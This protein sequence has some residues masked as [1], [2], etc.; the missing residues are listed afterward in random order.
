MKVTTYEFHVPELARDYT[1]LMLSDLHGRRYRSLLR[2]VK[3]LKPD[4]ILLCG[5][6]VDRHYKLYKRTLPFFTKIANVAPTYFA[7][8]NHEVKFPVLSKEAMERT[9]VTVLDNRFV[10][11]TDF[12]FGGLTPLIGEAEEDLHKAFSCDCC[13][14]PTP[15]VEENIRWLKDFE[16]VPKFKILLNHRPEE[17]FLYLDRYHIDLTLSGHAHG[18]QWV[19]FGRPILA[20]GQGLF[21]NYAHGQFG[22][23]IV[24][25][26]CSNTC[27][28]FIPRIHNP[29]ELVLLRFHQN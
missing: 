18:G 5:D 25:A 13:Y 3:R 7:Y 9:G 22:K 6:F 24:G 23:L 11:V 20:P 21:P 28:P 27:A 10:R 15:E 4:Y 16:Q 26:G 2:R 1:V 12:A 14:N 29:K 19:L 17:Y 8:G